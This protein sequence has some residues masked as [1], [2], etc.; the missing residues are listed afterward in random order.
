MEGTSK[1]VT[2]I[3]D[4]FLDELS[5][6]DGIDSDFKSGLSGLLKDDKKVTGQKLE[7]MIY[8]EADSV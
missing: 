7:Q 3:V 5:S 4:K 8:G 6:I 2:E 1:I